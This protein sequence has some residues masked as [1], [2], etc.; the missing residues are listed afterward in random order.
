MPERHAA[1]LVL[2]EHGGKFALNLPCFG[3]VIEFRQFA[4]R[5]G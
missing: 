1:K 5:V 4:E 3:L 2:D